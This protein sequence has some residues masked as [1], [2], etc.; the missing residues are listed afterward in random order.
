MQTS[1]PWIYGAGRR[2]SG[3]SGGGYAESQNPLTV[4][5]GQGIR[6]INAAAINSGTY[7]VIRISIQML[8]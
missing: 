7:L 2:Y 4:A 5:Y 6:D 8:S 3:I 1:G